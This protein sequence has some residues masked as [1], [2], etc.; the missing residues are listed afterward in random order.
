MRLYLVLTICICI[1]SAMSGRQH[2]PALCEMP[3]S[4]MY[5]NCRGVCQ[6]KRGH[7][8]DHRCSFCGYTWH[9]Y[10]FDARLASNHEQR[11]PVHKDE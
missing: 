10:E 5:K 8:S 2:Q 11:I 4:N 6:K 9:Q 3:C 7:R 1:V